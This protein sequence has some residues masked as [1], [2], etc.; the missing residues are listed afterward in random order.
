LQL[1]FKTLSGLADSALRRLRLKSKLA[2]AA[3]RIKD[4][5]NAQL[6]SRADEAISTRAASFGFN[7]LGLA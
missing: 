2:P 7:E 3:H 1:V 6:L 5:L 4:V